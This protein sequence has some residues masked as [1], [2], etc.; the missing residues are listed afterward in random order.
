[1]LDLYD[2]EPGRA[3]NTPMSRPDRCASPPGTPPNTN[4]MLTEPNGTKRLVH[5][6]GTGW[7]SLAWEHREA[8]LQERISTTPEWAHTHGYRYESAEGELVPEIAT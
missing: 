1:M 6:N 5:W 3:L 2:D 8:P 4:H 7:N